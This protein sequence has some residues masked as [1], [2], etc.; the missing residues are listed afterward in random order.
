LFLPSWPAL[1]TR[2]DQY[3]REYTDYYRAHAQAD[4]PGLRDPNPSV[5]V[6]PGLGIFG[7]GR[8]KRGANHLSSS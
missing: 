7:F 3:R 2:L 1:D 8:D 6:I 4:S 5:V